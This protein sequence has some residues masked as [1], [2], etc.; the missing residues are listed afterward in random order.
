M[1][2]SNAILYAGGEVDFADINPD[3]LQPDLA[4]VKDKLQGSTGTHVEIIP[5]DFAGLP[6]A[7]DGFNSS[8]A[9]AGYGY[10][11]MR[12]MLRSG[13]YFNDG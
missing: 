8:G 5:V 7:M 11:K 1:A 3:T 2:T 9:R 4:E 10:W 6:V 12:A 13:Y